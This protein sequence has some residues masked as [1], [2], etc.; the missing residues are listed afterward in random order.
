MANGL[1]LEGYS[2][3][4]G[5][6]NLDLPDLAPATRLP[7]STGVS[8]GRAADIAP[9][10]AAPGGGPDIAGML[11]YEPT[12]RDR[13]AAF[14]HGIG[15]ND[16]GATGKYLNALTET[17]RKAGMDL[18]N[19]QINFA[20][21][22]REGRTQTMVTTEKVFGL[23]D[24]IA[25]KLSAMSPDEVETTLK[26]LEQIAE[27]GGA[28]SAKALVRPLAKNPDL[29]AIVPGLLPLIPR[30]VQQVIGLQ[31]PKAIA[32]GRMPSLLWA[33]ALPELQR[34]L[35]QE[36]EQELD[37]LSLEPA[38]RDQPVPY[39]VLMRRITRGDRIRE[40]YIDRTYGGTAG[41]EI[42]AARD[43]FDRRLAQKG[44]ALPSTAAKAQETAATTAA[45]KRA[46]LAPDIVKGEAAA[47]AEKTQAQE[48]AKLTA[49]PFGME[50]ARLRLQEL[51]NNV[52]QGNF[53]GLT[54]TVTNYLKADPT[55]KDKPT[56]AQVQ[57]AIERSEGALLER[58]RQQGLAAGN[59]PA[60]TPETEMKL[61]QNLALA[62][63]MLD[64]LARLTPKVNLPK[65]A[66]GLAPWFNKIAETGRVGP[67]PVDMRG[68]SGGDRRFLALTRD[69]AD[70]VLRMRSGAQ[71]NEQEFARMLGFLP[72]EQATPATV[73]ARLTLQRDLL[74]ARQ[75]IQ[76]QTLRG[77]GYRAPEVTPPTLGGAG[78][79]TIE[80]VK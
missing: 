57:R 52:E 39:D 31:A 54:D 5:K 45:Q 20:R 38:Y 66:G 12:T 74:R 16:P 32:E 62:Q 79:W 64:E 43:A 72:V 25:P 48:I 10:G 4:A 13:W 78:G 24:T 69:Y 80:R 68:L 41:K 27:E 65:I 34:Q 51:R 30:N 47:A 6:L 70:T 44:V 28:R 14:F 2:L 55:V 36:A 75:N 18:A 19:Y 77:G 76:A 49:K 53:A 7:L 17:K 40:M 29:A 22:M 23:V 33:N 35:N 21:E 26:G 50:E 67:L 42:D 46:G 58:S 56:Q 3:G 11:N 37:A 73:R 59:I 71:I 1:P 15:S 60:R 61:F 63:S 9:S 8:T